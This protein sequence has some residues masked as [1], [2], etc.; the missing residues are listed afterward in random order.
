M[1]KRHQQ[2]LTIV[3]RDRYT[4]LK[5]QYNEYVISDLYEGETL[6]GHL[7]DTYAEARAY[8]NNLNEGHLNLLQWS[9]ND[10]V[11]AV[12]LELF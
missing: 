11:V 4:V 7:W 2:T 3:A 5:I 1:T 6:V 10:H 8:C 9:M 12:Q